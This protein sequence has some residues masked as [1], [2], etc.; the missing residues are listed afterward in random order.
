MS[1]GS[2]LPRAEGPGGS[3]KVIKA[4]LGSKYPVGPTSTSTPVEVVSDEAYYHSEPKELTV[5]GA[6]EFKVMPA[7]WAEKP[8]KSKPYNKKE[9]KKKEEKT[10][11][12]VVLQT[13][14]NRAFVEVPPTILK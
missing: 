14:P 12:P 9:L 11:P 6:M 3:A 8:K 2:N 5:L 1:D 10:V 7:E 4:R 13:Q